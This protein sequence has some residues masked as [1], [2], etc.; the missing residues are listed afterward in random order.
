MDETLKA[1]E[2]YNF[3]QGS[4]PKLGYIR[5]DYTDK[6]I[7]FSGNNLIKVLVGQ[8]R[9]GKSY[10]LRQTAARLIENGIDK[11]NI[12]FINRE[13]SEFS[14]LK[15]YQDLEK[16]ITIYKTAIQPKGKIYLFLDEVQN[17]DQWEI[18]INSLSQDYVDEYEIFITGSNS[19]ML[20]GELATLLSGRYIQMEI[21]PFSYKEFIGITNKERS[22][23]SFLE[24]LSSGGLPELFQLSSDEIKKNYVSALKD[25]I[26]LRDI[27]FRN[28]IKEGRLLEDVFAYLVNTASNLVSI[29]NI[30][31][32][33]KFNVHKTSYDTIANYI[34]FIQETYLIHRV[35]R[36]NIRGKDIISGNAKYYVNDLSFSNYLYRGFAYGVGYMLENLIYLELRRKGYQVYVGS[37]AGKEVDFVAHKDDK[38]MYI[39]SAYLLID[40][41]T[42]DREYNSLEQI[43]DNFEKLVVSM[44]EVAMPSKDGIKHIQAWNLDMAL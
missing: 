20:S 9:S 24:Y 34:H 10:I 3:W 7:E 8:R 33:F 4:I 15:T 25:T 42:I 14:F 35:E 17:I 11:R 37:I 22:K 43:N 19:K 6:I 32:Y 5:N 26:L 36:Y 16:L 38:K 1:L 39:Q 40:K 13:F 23:N 21:F 31:N 44:D 2:K 18:I 27:I 30:A 28:N 41:A 12:I 29:R